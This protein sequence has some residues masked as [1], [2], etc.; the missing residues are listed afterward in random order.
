[1]SQNPPNL[2]DLD[3]FDESQH[4]RGKTTDQS[5]PGSF[6]PKDAGLTKEER[7]SEAWDE[8]ESTLTDL[9][10][11]TM[12]TYLGTAYI[13]I[14]EF[15]RSGLPAVSEDDKKSAE[16]AKIIDGM[17]SRAPGW[18][19]TSYRGMGLSPQQAIEFTNT[20]IIEMKAFTSTAETRQIAKGFLWGGLQP[21]ATF[22]RVQGKH[23][24]I[25]NAFG[26]DEGEILFKTGT[27]FRVTID[28]S[29]LKS[30]KPSM[31]MTWKEI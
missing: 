20:K 14:N 5:T 6:A 11:D 10:V 30:S 31:T 9:E 16:E 4:P 15:L 1:M 27:R 28:K 25:V 21:V 22:V 26:G 17:L 19:G 18:P 3:A 13:R 24:V 12:Q 2:I 29:D 23:G 7:H 8:W